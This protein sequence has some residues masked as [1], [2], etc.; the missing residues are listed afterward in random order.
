MK[1]MLSGDYPVHIFT[2]THDKDDFLYEGEGSV[3][4]FDHATPVKVLWDLEL[5]ITEQEVNEVIKELVSAEEAPDDVERKIAQLLRRSRKGQKK[6]KI[7][8]LEVYEGGM[9]CDGL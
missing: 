6:L 1:M 8:Q 7:K 4:E 5:A 3:V 9:L 2:R